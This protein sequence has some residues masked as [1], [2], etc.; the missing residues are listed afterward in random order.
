MKYDACVKLHESW[1]YILNLLFKSSHSYFQDFYNIKNEKSHCLPGI[2]LYLSVATGQMGIFEASWVI[3]LHSVLFYIE[4]MHW[5]S[6][7]RWS[8]AFYANCF[9]FEASFSVLHC[10][11]FSFIA[12]KWQEAALKIIQE[13]LCETRRASLELLNGCNL[14]H[15]TLLPSMS[16]NISN[17]T[18]FHYVGCDEKDSTKFLVPKTIC[19]VSDIL[20]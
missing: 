1:K 7:D 16:L 10:T 20:S 11:L 19:N 13:N 18:V 6:A 12:H 3:N 9:E 14:A 4:Y 17:F 8:C 2:N 5:L 15:I